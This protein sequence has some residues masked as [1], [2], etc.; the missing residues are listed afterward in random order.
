MVSTVKEMVPSCMWNTDGGNYENWGIVI[1][2]V[3]NIAKKNPKYIDSESPCFFIL[4]IQ[5]SPLN[6]KPK[7]H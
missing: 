7:K 3:F 6:I 1:R 5:Y 4:S 2:R